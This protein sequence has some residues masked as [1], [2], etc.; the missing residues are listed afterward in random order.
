MSQ[1][2][3]LLYAPSDQI[4]A[5]QVRAYLQAEGIA[6]VDDQDADAW[7]IML[8]VLSR[9]ANESEN[10]LRRVSATLAANKILIPFRV[11]NFRPRGEM[12]DYLRWRYV[13]EAFS[14]PLDR[15]LEELVRMIKPLLHGQSMRLSEATS[16]S[17]TL[18]SRAAILQKSAREETGRPSSDPV[19]VSLNFPHFVLAGLPTT[20]QCRV[21]NLLARPLAHL[22][23]LVECRGLKHAVDRSIDT[24][25]ASGRETLAFEIE[26]GGF[27]QFNLRINLQGQQDDQIVS[28]SGTHPLR[29]HEAPAPADFPDALQ[30]FSQGAESTTISQG[31]PLELPSFIASADELSRFKLP[32]RFESLDLVLDHEVAA[33]AVQRARNNEPLTIP[34]GFLDQAQPGTFLAL[35]PL[36]PTDTPHQD[37]RLVARP[38][39]TLGRSVEESDFI[40]WFWPRNEVH[41]TKTRRMSKKHVTLAFDGDRLIAVNNAAGSLTTYEGQDVAAVG[42]ELQ[43]RG[44][45]N[46]SGIYLLDVL[47]I[48]GSRPSLHLTNFDA[49]QGHSSSPASPA[50]RGCVRLSP[51]SAQVLPQNSTWLFSEATFGGNKINPVLLDLEGLADIQGRFH[52]HHGAFWVESFAGNSAVQLQDQTLAPGQIAPLCTGQVLRLGT[53]RFTVSVTASP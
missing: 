8:L 50:K 12:Q 4:V 42:I 35:T 23:V 10:V 7:S 21:E 52:Y 39:F 25:P 48:A 5:D 40:L 11:Q 18:P 41:D 43:R 9:E 45:L 1:P 24:L 27:G 20:M 26:P 44:L 46:L 22:R 47:W 6:C 53:G 30:R 31:N 37:I 14:L 13:H 33:E 28:F 38:H 3:C 34:P 15:H 36:D 16:I 51:R 32:D 19:Q 2:V 17:R 49:W 29:I